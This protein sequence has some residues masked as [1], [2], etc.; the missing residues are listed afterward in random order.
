ML[1]IL[2]SPTLKKNGS[3]IHSLQNKLSLFRDLTPTDL[4]IRSLIYSFN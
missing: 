4:G 2:H 1:F 3:H